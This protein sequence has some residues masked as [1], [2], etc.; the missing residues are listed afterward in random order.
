MVTQQ[1]FLESLFNNYLESL[2]N[3]SLS[4]LYHSKRIPRRYNSNNVKLIIKFYHFMY[5]HIEHLQM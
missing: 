5:T 2:L 4:T 3:N 1:P